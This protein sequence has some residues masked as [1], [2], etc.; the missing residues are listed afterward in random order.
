MTLFDETSEPRPT[1]RERPGGWL[2]L[3]VLL[4]LV[5]LAGGGYAIA[6]Q[7]A[8][9]KVPLGT[10]VSGIDVGGLTRAEAI[11]KL[12]GEFD[13]RAA[14]PI[15]LTVGDG[16][17]RTDV[18]PDDIG[19]TIEEVHQIATSVAAAVE[20]QQAA[21]QEI[22]RNV[23][24]AAKGTQ[25]VSESIVQV[26]GAATHAGA[27]ASQVLAAAGELSANSNALSREVDGFLQGVR[28]A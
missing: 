2:V 20:E 25:D 1:K 14:T 21:T 22:A 24:E 19:L 27:A 9:D 12:R 16:G 28:A 18:R 8:G 10:K 3:V 4:V 15:E 11:A 17:R 7:V 13:E 5:L 26:Q 6:H 23:S